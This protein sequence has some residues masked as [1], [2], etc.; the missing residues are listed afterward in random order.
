[1]N[2][3]ELAAKLPTHP[4]LGNWLVCP[5]EYQA[6]AYVYPEK[7]GNFYQGTGFTRAEAVKLTQAL[8]GETE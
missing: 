7:M 6:C 1:M 4:L 5:C 2:K 8:N 3:Y